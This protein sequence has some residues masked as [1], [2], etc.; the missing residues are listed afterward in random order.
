MKIQRQVRKVVR[1]IPNKQI[2]ELLEI[3]KEA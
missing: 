3:K 1:G 2:S